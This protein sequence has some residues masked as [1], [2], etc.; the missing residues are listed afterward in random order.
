MRVVFDK[1]SVYI[2][3]TVGHGDQLMAPPEWHSSDGKTE[4]IM[5]FDASWNQEG[6]YLPDENYKHG[7]PDRTLGALIHE[8]SLRKGD[9][10]VSGPTRVSV[11][12]T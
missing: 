12:L 3:G 11:R 1:T 4:L 9:N 7:I 6:S 8:L 5:P 2:K 10:I